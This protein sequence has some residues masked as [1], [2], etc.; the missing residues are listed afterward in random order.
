MDAPRDRGDQA[1]RQVGQARAVRLARLVT[2]SPPRWEVALMAVERPAS[3]A[4]R[5]R[6]SIA[7]GTGDYLGVD[8]RGPRVGEAGR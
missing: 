4:A 7:A 2:D 6:S 3:D 5:R 1:P 8:E